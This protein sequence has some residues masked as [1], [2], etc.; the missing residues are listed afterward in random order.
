MKFKGF[1]AYSI[2][3]KAG[4]F[5]PFLIALILSFPYLSYA[6]NPS[7]ELA[8]EVLREMISKAA[9]KSQSKIFLG[10][11]G[12]EREAAIQAV[13][14]KKRYDPKVVDAIRSNLETPQKALIHIE[15]AQIGARLSTFHPEW[16]K[17]LRSLAQ[18]EAIVRPMI[19]TATQIMQKELVTL[20]HNPA[21]HQNLL[22]Y[23]R[24]EIQKVLQE[25]KTHPGSLEGLSDLE[26]TLADI[27]MLF[28]SSLRADTFSRG[29]VA[30]M[31]DFLTH[32]N[33]KLQQSIQFLQ[34][35]IPEEKGV[36]IIPPI[37][38]G[39]REGVKLSTL[40]ILQNS[41]ERYLERL[42]TLNRL[43]NGYSFSL[44]STGL[45][46]VEL[47]FLL[48]QIRFGTL[49]AQQFSFHQLVRYFS[50][51]K[52]RMPEE[53]L[54]EMLSSR[55]NIFRQSVIESYKKAKAL[56]F[57]ILN[58]LDREF[59]KTRLFFPGEKEFEEAIET[60][61]ALI[62]YPDEVALGKALLIAEK[63]AVEKVGTIRALGHLD[64][65][66]AFSIILEVLPTLGKMHD[67]L[68]RACLEELVSNVKIHVGG[69]V[70]SLREV[71][72]PLLKEAN[73]Q[74]QKEVILALSQFPQPKSVAQ[75]VR[76][77]LSSLDPELRV[78][79]A[80][81]FSEHEPQALYEVVKAL[82]LPAQ[83]LSSETKLL[84]LSKIKE[85]IS[86]V[87]VLKTSL[88]HLAEQD[89]SVAVRLE[90]LSLLAR[91]KDPQ[92]VSGLL[93][94]FDEASGSQK[95]KIIIELLINFDDR[96]TLRKTVK[97]IVEFY[98][99][100]RYQFDLFDII[101]QEYVLGQRLA[102]LGKD[103]EILKYIYSLETD[104]NPGLAEFIAICF[105]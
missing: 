27:E 77:F 10:S 21:S 28:Q 31:E 61:V 15:G 98:Q 48:A 17:F 96:P 57:P 5:K 14:A 103:P 80:V 8:A 45:E 94:L 101:G 16:E 68:F 35:M 50:S 6:N 70:Q 84:V 36:L 102:S 92:V 9:G 75:T 32:R 59:F 97:K 1:L 91:S 83:A 60:M 22:K 85:E 86:D 95:R 82:E 52:Q 76:P 51:A 13:L 63:T 26:K 79:A 18:D 90:A 104:S 53:V 64:S 55:N 34:G 23:Y 72:V 24:E 2:S 89:S 78:A 30:A 71:L 12:A 41:T 44:L 58:A 25:I 40:R 56:P 81:F 69:R 66:Y 88:L 49:E 43:I 46:G 73:V 42:K 105:Q 19:V 38:A 33:A 11:W 54:R 37:A 93:A 67:V 62:S 65:H 4:I 20:T 99:D 39:G 74:T 100:P 29:A 3:A 87:A 7:Y 47:E